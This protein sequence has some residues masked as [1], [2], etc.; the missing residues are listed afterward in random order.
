MVH[1]A[2]TKLGSHGSDQPR[3]E[4]R[5][6]AAEDDGR[7]VQDVEKRRKRDTERGSGLL[8]TEECRRLACHRS[9]DELWYGF[10][11]TTDGGPRLLRQPC[12]CKQRLLA[13]Y[14]FEATAGHHSCMP[15]PS[16]PR[17]HD[18]AHLRGLGHRETARHR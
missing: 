17:S 15:V 6:E 18:R 2:I 13:G 1:N 4:L 16:D 5:V 8:Q 7:Q 14:A 10:D 9:P 3:C 11:R 12:G